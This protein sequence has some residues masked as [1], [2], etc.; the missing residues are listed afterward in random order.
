MN[1]ILSSKEAA[2]IIGISDSTVRAHANKG[3]IPYEMSG[4]AY[5][6][7][8]KDVEAYAKKY[9]PRKNRLGGIT[10]SSTASKWFN[11]PIGATVNARDT[12]AS[13]HT[14]IVADANG[15]ILEKYGEVIGNLILELSDKD[16]IRRGLVDVDG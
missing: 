15:Y 6:F 3:L 7:L 9:V 5:V 10:T 2:K 8:R 13:R 11:S 4:T 14:E 12:I 16:G 1:N